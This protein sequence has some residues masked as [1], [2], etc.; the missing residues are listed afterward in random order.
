MRSPRPDALR[1]GC[2]PTVSGAASPWWGVHRRRGVRPRAGPR[3]DRGTGAEDDAHVSLL[4]LNTGWAG[5]GR[6]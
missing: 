3:V 4:A 2:R 5:G 6:P 1:L